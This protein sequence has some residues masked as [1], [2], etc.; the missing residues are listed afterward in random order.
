MEV[1]DDG[2]RHDGYADFPG[3]KSDTAPFQVLHNTRGSVQAE[4]TP[5]TQEDCVHALH[6]MAGKARSQ[7]TRAR[8]GTADIDSAD[9]ARFAEDHTASCQTFEVAC[10]SDAD[11]WNCVQI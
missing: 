11:A 8:S 2:A 7:I 10:V 3:R 5:S 9:A 4:S 1:E 6:H